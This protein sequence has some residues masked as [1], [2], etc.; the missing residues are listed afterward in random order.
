M[1]ML[2]S[3]QAS[4]SFCSEELLSHSSILVTVK[5]SA[6]ASIKEDSVCPSR[7]LMHRLKDN[8]FNCV[9]GNIKAVMKRE[10]IGGILDFLAL[11]RGEL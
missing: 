5:F 3:W 9:S 2:M 11:G 8:T 10:E 4:L 6:T 7:D 1:Y